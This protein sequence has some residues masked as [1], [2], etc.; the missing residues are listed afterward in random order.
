MRCHLDLAFMVVTV[1]NNS[2]IV[3]HL[4]GPGN[5]GSK[6]LMLNCQT[7]GPRGEYCS[8]ELGLI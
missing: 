4:P 2:I 6:V 7:R 5:M 3:L 1:G 8:S